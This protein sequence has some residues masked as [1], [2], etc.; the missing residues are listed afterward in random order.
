MI[1]PE[2]TWLTFIGKEKDHDPLSNLHMPFLPFDSTVFM[3]RKNDEEENFQ[4]DEVY[5]KTTIGLLPLQIQPW[6]VWFHFGKLLSTI[7]PQWQRRK[8]LTGVVFRATGVIVNIEI[9]LG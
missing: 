1:K 4:I 8:N 6:G 2:H 3:V 7:A 9:L 5:H